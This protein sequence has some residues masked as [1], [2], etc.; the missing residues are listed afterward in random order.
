MGRRGLRACG[1]PALIKPGFSSK[2]KF[3]ASLARSLSYDPGFCTA[4]ILTGLG[5]SIIFEQ[6]VAD[7]SADDSWNEIEVFGEHVIYQ[8]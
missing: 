7:F 2:R 6:N 1:S 4:E 5:I 3:V 8:T